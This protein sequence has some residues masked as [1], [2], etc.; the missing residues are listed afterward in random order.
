MNSS[1]I[2]VVRAG[3]PHIAALT[4]AFTAT[5][6]VGVAGQGDANRGL[7]GGVRADV[8]FGTGL[9]GTGNDTC[10]R[11]AFAGGVGVR[12]QGPLIVGGTAELIG[13][14]G[15]T[16]G[17][18]LQRVE[19]AEVVVEEGGMSY[20]SGATPRVGLQ[21]GGVFDAG[22]FNLEPIARV[23]LVKFRTNYRY[24]R[25]RPLPQGGFE[26]WPSELGF[27]TW[28]PWLSAAIGVL[29]TGWG[30]GLR[31]GFGAVRTP[32]RHYTTEGGGPIADFHEWKSFG[33]WTMS[34][35][36]GRAA[37][38]TPEAVGFP[39][40][41]GVRL[42]FLNHGTGYTGGACRPNPLALT[43]GVTASARGKLTVGASVDF[44]QTLRHGR[45]CQL[46]GSQ[47]S[48]D[49]KTV[50]DFGPR[51]AAWTGYGRR[52]GATWIEVGPLAGMTRSRT[53]YEGGST[54]PIDETT[55]QPLVGGLVGVQVEPPAFGLRLMIGEHRVPRRTYDEAGGLAREFHRWED[56]VE[57]MLEVPLN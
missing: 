13:S 29:G 14:V 16:C 12:T 51:L 19:S 45:D 21:V 9:Y 27:Q 34:L 32:R 7:F 56:F 11:P 57:L 17:L 1:I 4:L 31:V 39:I 46:L 25:S 55:W 5:L 43:G 50:L 15:L 30:P 40:D 26:G 36:F 44:I 24:G 18:Q 48:Y 47:D 53:R 10:A 54:N 28:Q 38:A 41:V 49:G 2:V 8:T 20:F 33:E 3:W 35:P 6:P 23:G 42:G 37:A 52:L 22:D